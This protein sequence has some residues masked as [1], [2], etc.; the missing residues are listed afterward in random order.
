MTDQQKQLSEH[1]SRFV[2]EHKK[3]FIERVLALRT[4]HLTIVLE[5]VYQS[6][7]ASA[8]LR[9]CECMG[10]QDVHIIEQRSKY[11][12]NPRVLKGAN[13]WMN[14]HR[15]NNRSVNNT[16]LCYNYLR[17]NGYRILAADPSESGASIHD[18]EVVPQK[19]ALVFGNELRGLSDYALNEADQKVRIPMY[20]FT[21]SLNLSVS[22][23]ICVNTLLNKLHRETEFCSL[24]PEEK[25]ILKLE[26]YRKIVRGSEIIEREF[27][28]SID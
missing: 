23:A 16:M 22:A 6:Q 14:L 17:E 19:V 13:K 15:Y 21:E 10:V 24:R 9:T 1:L 12:I 20:G 28:R 8:V 5:D 25:D 4:R 26:W 7:N 27:L 11:D 18:V 3:N 2:S